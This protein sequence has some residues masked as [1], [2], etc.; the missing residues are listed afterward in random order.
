MREAG[1]L[2]ALRHVEAYLR[3]EAATAEKM[4]RQ[5]RSSVS[6]HDQSGEHCGTVW[7]RNISEFQMFIS[8][9]SLLSESSG[10][11]LGEAVLALER[12]ATN[13]LYHKPYFRCPLCARRTGQLILAR[14]AWACRECHALTYRSQRLG[15]AQRQQQRLDELAQLLRPVRGQP[16]RPR[17]MRS[18]RFA[19]LAAEYAALRAALRH[20]PRL[21][22]EGSLGLTLTPSWGA[23]PPFG[24]G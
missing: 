4:V 23:A 15:P 11:S 24:P 20:T 17:Y 1:S 19:Q 22:P 2:A 12:V 21:V 3:L 7:I 6:W 9:S 18:E 16:V 13:A 10:L 14:E 8:Y 5:G